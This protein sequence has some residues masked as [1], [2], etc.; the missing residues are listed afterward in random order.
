MSAPESINDAQCWSYPLRSYDV[1]TNLSAEGWTSPAVLPHYAADIK[2]GGSVPAYRSVKNKTEK[3]NEPDFTASNNAPGCFF[4]STAPALDQQKATHERNSSSQADG[5]GDIRGSSAPPIVTAAM[6]PNPP[7]FFSRV[8]DSPIAGSDALL[9]ELVLPIAVRLHNVEEGQKLLGI[10]IR[11]GK[12]VNGV[13]RQV[14]LRLTDPLDPF[15]LYEMELREEDYGLFKQRLELVVDFNGFPRFL[16]DMLHGIDNSTLPY[17]VTFLAHGPESSRGILRIIENTP[18]RTMEQLS[19]CL[20]RQGDAGQKK[21]LAE[22]FQYFEC[23]YRKGTAAWKSERDRLKN[24]LEDTRRKLDDITESYQTLQERQ[25]SSETCKENEHSRTISSIRTQHNLEMKTEAEKHSAEVKALQDDFNRS[26]QE[27]LS[28]LRQ[29][30]DLLQH[31]QDRC[32]EQDTQYVQLDGKYR[33]IEATASSLESEVQS[34]RQTSIE[35]KKSYD[36]SLESLRG[37][38][39]ALA[40][41]SERLNGLTAALVAKS[42]E[43][44]SLKEQH[45]QQNTLVSSLTS[46][47]KQLS[48]NIKTL[49]K[50]IEKAHYIIGTQLQS[51]KT[52]KDRYR[53]ATEQ[54]QTQEQLLSERQITLT[55]V[56]EELE[57]T[58]EKMFRVEQRDEKLEADLEKSSSTQEKLHTELQNMREALKTLGKSTSTSGHYFP[59]RIVHRASSTEMTPFSSASNRSFYGGTAGFRSPFYQPG[60]SEEMKKEF[61]SQAG[62]SPSSKCETTNERLTLSSGQSAI[63][64]SSSD[65]V[66]LTQPTSVKSTSNNLRPSNL[67]SLDFG[68]R[69]SHFSTAVRSDDVIASSKELS[70]EQAV[71]PTPHHVNDPSVVASD[72]KR[73]P[74]TT[75]SPSDPKIPFEKMRNKGFISQHAK[76]SFLV[77][78][79]PLATPQSAYF[80]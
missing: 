67:S 2:I 1:A 44:D 25:R 69:I 39:L 55:R 5:T 8:D 20:V 27:L 46:Q 29:K 45:D 31:L 51:L 66:H 40:T 79:G 70:M 80:A 34:L 6:T 22:R 57:N 59:H 33:L 7:S 53:I 19:L 71:T 24:S 10:S 23:A 76:D 18:F 38:D 56:K 61:P 74:S 17:V 72:G 60:G 52:L 16:S 47:N 62:F 15:F 35:L 78:E 48:E 3:R 12:A 26:Q 32:S 49:E 64:S 4:A 75:R 65:P 37:K 58:K 43:F 68:S 36:E 11:C 63:A 50:N 28:N 30:D 9:L 14:L 42:S 54:I 13:S 77:S 41:L 73:Y 21:H